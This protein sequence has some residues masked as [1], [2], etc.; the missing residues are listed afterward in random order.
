MELSGQRFINAPRSKVWRALQDAPTLD[1]CL[2]QD[3][4]VKRV[5]PTEI[6]VGRPVNGRVAITQVAPSAL[7]YQASAGRLHLT[8]L[9]EGPAI[10][11][12]AYVLEAASFDAAR[13]QT[14]ID[15]LLEAFQVQVSGPQEIA[16]GGLA[17]ALDAGLEA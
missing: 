13:A 10:T 7:T 17:G 14:E 3:N 15:Q 12:L 9:E 5:S 1:G 4:A 8:L 11:R 16:A 2:Q 6:E